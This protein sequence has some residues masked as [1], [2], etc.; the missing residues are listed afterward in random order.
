MPANEQSEY[1]LIPSEQARW[2]VPSAVFGLQVLNA[3]TEII[4]VAVRQLPEGVWLATSDDLPGLIVETAT[5]DE[6]I[7]LSR[8][9]A[10]ELLEAEGR[11]ADRAHQKFAFIFL[12]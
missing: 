2:L 6:T 9:L 12:P 11:D 3:S 8:E 5:R 4:T 7:D 1:V 10:F